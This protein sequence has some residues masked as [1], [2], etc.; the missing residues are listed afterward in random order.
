MLLLTLL[1]TADCSVGGGDGALAVAAVLLLLGTAGAT[2]AGGEWA[3]M[4][5]LPSA[6]PLSEVGSKSW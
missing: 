1:L 6:L 5:S 4:F 3:G 2:A